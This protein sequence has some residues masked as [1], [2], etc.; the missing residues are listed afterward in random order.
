MLPGDA[1]E[2]MDTAVL[3]VGRLD[4]SPIYLSYELDEV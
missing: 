2:T 4:E 3:D 1:W